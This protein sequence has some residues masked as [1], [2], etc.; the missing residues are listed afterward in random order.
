MVSRFSGNSASAGQPDRPG[1]AAGH[2]GRGLRKPQA[3]YT[4][5]ALRHLQEWESGVHQPQS[6]I[7]FFGNWQRY[8]STIAAPDHG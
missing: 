6:Q 7:E 5:A 4:P 2:A 1:S 8:Q 3:D